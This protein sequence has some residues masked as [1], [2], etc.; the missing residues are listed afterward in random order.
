MEPSTWGIIAAG[1]VVVVLLLLVLVVRARRRGRAAGRSAELK[2]RF[3]PE[4]DRA[5]EDRGRDEA[6]AELEGRVDRYQRTATRPLPREERRRA[7]QRWGE[8]QAAYVDDPR[9]AIQ[10]AETLF[11]RILDERQMPA[12]RLDDRVTAA[13]FVRPG[14]ADQYRRAHQVF[15]DVEAERTGPGDEHDQR[16]AFLVYREL[17]L[18]HTREP[19]GD[20]VEIIDEVRVVADVPVT[21]GQ[22][23]D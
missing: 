8:L 5:V 4:Y 1:A 9:V 16:M 10:R 19:S 22:P 23:S 14:L 7:L 21:S 3:G 11:R 20:H 15:I 6:E 13:A 12:D 17:V 2:D 18:E